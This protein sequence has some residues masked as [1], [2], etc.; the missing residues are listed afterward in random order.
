MRINSCF[1]PKGNPL[2]SSSTAER[3]PPK[4]LAQINRK[5]ILTIEICTKIFPPLPSKKILEER[6]HRILRIRKIDPFRCFSNYQN[7]TLWSQEIK[8]TKLHL[9]AVRK[10]GVDN[11]LETDRP[12]TTTQEEHSK[13]SMSFLT[14]LLFNLRIALKR[15]FRICLRHCCTEFSVE[16]GVL[17]KMHIVK[18]ATLMQQSFLKQH[19][20]LHMKLYTCDRKV[21]S[22]NHPV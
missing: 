5:I 19:F 17:K 7:T 21:I 3:P 20:I 9:K 12:K 15:Y 2:S 1:L 8:N 13:S 22:R 4:I 18:I 16:N 6:K 11:K 10:Q 14:A